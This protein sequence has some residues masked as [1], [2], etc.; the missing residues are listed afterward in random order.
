MYTQATI[1]F[2]LRCKSRIFYLPTSILKFISAE[3]EGILIV[4]VSNTNFLFLDKMMV[5][6]LKNLHS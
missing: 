3:R 5:I 4:A 1:N 6:D 2:Y